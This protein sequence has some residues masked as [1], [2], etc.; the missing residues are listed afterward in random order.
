MRAEIFPFGYREPQFVLML[1][2][3][4]G[5]PLREF[6]LEARPCALVLAVVLV[7][8]KP[9]RFLRADSCATRAKS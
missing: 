2:P 4:L 5:S 6:C 8:E 7:L 3:D 9:E 1:L